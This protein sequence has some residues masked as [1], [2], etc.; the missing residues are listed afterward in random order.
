MENIKITVIYKWRHGDMVDYKNSA[1][2]ARATKTSKRL[3]EEI[4]AGRA[5][6]TAKYDFVYTAGISKPTTFYPLW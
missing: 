5:K 1:A 4:A 2:A 6:P 3:V